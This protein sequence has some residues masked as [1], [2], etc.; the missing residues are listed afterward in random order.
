MHK[1]VLIQ[2]T[3]TSISGDHGVYGYGWGPHTYYLISKQSKSGDLCLDD[4]SLL[5]LHIC[6]IPGWTEG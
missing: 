4:I 1:M 2:A 3:S 6:M 5:I